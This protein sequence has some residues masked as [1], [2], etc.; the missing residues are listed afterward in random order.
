MDRLSKLS[1][2]CTLAF[3]IALCPVSVVEAVNVQSPLNK[4][5]LS[6][7]GPGPVK[8]TSE[9]NVCIFCH[10]PHGAITEAGAANGPLWNRKI[11]SASYQLYQS[12]TLLSPTS[13]AIQPDGDSK[14]CL[15]C[16]DGTI[17]IGAVV[18]TGGSANSISM[19]GAGPGGV[20]PPGSTNI[21][22]ELSG[23]H[24]ISI[25]VNNAFIADK[26][27][28]CNSHKVSFG[29]C[30]PTAYAKLMKTKN[31][32]GGSSGQGV[33]CTSCHDPHEDPIPGTTS[34]LR[35]GD[36]MNSDPLCNDCH[37]E[38]SAGCP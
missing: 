10:T 38:C 30:Y 19:S 28:Q 1:S 34:F 14:L 15:S 12:Q 22:T 8:A 18:N 24:P 3:L 20:M 2:L 23:H 25:A 4:H 5:N 9:R 6:I 26:T 27:A 21:G 7:T 29:I 36:K 32:Y 11:S 13:P 33:Q 17:A 16:H 35:G 37:K 31:T